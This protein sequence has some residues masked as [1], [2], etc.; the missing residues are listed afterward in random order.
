VI[1]PGWARLLL[2]EF[3]GEVGSWLDRV[4][5]DHG[6]AFTAANVEYR[7][8]QAQSRTAYQ[9]ALD[10][11]ETGT[12]GSGWEREAGDQLV[13]L[14]PGT[15]LRRVALGSPASFSTL[16]ADAAAVASFHHQS[17]PLLYSALCNSSQRGVSG[18]GVVSLEYPVGSGTF[19]TDTLFPPPIAVTPGAPTE[20]S[21]GRVTKGLR[22][23]GFVVQHRSGCILRP[24]PNVASGAP[25]Y[26]TFRPVEFTCAGA[27]NLSWTITA[28]WPT[29]AV[30]VWLLVSTVSNRSLLFFVPGQVQPVTGGTTHAITFTWDLSDEELRRAAEEDTQFAASSLL[31]LTTQQMDGT[32]PFTPHRIFSVGDRL[33]YLT[34]IADAVGGREGAIL[35]SDRRHHQR[36]SLSTSLKQLTN[37]PV[38]ITGVGVDRICTVFTESGTWTTGE[39]SN[40]PVQWADF[41]LRDGNRG[42]PAIN[43]V[44]VDQDSGSV[45]V[46]TRQGLN[47]FD[48]TR[49][50]AE[51][52]SLLQTDRWNTINWNYAYRLRV[53]GDWH[54][55]LVHVFAPTGGSGAI[56][57]WTWCYDQGVR[58]DRCNFAPTSITGYSPAT[59]VRV[60]NSLAAAD[61]RVKNRYEVWTLP[62]TGSG[63]MKAGRQ[64]E[65]NETDSYKET[66][67]TP[68]GAV[69][70]W[71]WQSTPIPD[72]LDVSLN[73]HFGVRFRA[74]GY[75]TLRVTQLSMDGAREQ[76]IHERE[77]LNNPENLMWAG[78]EMVTPRAMYKFE[79]V[80]PAGGWCVLSEFEA[81][82]MPESL[83]PGESVGP[84]GP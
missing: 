70:P 51:P 57:W 67:V 69:I 53:I 44:D 4:Q 62:A 12:H 37:K 56:E 14:K 19:V 15:G 25:G 33:V 65:Q 6:Y 21:A 64:L 11:N 42:T 3:K 24:S 9:S 74:Y 32:P 10:P 82:Y 52:V 29:S 47:V 26:D 60:R 20:P 27:K 34:T 84:D 38:P 54:R 40:K 2:R 78:G 61:H 30:K 66:L 80:E 77:L 45:W 72:R 31:T 58:W 28:A 76:V 43:G 46:A 79:V 73:R 13:Y 55:K 39:N 50:L 71:K 5:A 17:G 22:N 59:G 16:H 18:G 48:G 68:G 23:L 63:S 1:D 81:F 35:I 75:G 8:G 36:L 41:E 49:Y 83:L 7:R